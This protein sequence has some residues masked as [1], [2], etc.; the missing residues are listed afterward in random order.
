M[1]ASDGDGDLITYSFSSV[2][3]HFA[4]DASTGQIDLVKSLDRE[5]VQ[6]VRLEVWATDNGNLHPLTN[7]LFI[8]KVFSCLCH[9]SFNVVEVAININL[10]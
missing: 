5:I 6:E 3:G 8:Q 10:I 4:I 1:S 9:L 7:G 2:Y